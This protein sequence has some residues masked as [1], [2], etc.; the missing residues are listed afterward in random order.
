M[1][2][3]IKSF[4][5]IADQLD[6]AQIDVEIDDDFIAAEAAADELV[7]QQRIE[8]QMRELT[9]HLSDYERDVL[10]R[11]SS[12]GWS[13]T[14]RDS[15]MRNVEQ[16]TA[17]LLTT[18][19]AVVVYRDRDDRLQLGVVRSRYDFDMTLDVSPFPGAWQ[20][21]H[22]SRVELVRHPETL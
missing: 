20:R 6:G 4:E 19:S 14:R 9:P 18:P 2:D 21:V 13:M 5:R 12:R 17:A 10:L 7:E 8:Q 11:V 1:S 16:W 15:S 3:D 22:V